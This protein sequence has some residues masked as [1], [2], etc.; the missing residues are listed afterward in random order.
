MLL[1]TS[2]ANK[3]KGLSLYSKMV[4]GKGPLRLARM[5]FGR[6]AQLSTTFCTSL[7][8]TIVTGHDVR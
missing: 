3:D 4:P 7:K 8:A 2:I 5:N 6:E 1:A